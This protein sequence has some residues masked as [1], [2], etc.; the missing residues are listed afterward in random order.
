MLGSATLGVTMAWLPM[1]YLIGHAVPDDAFY[2]F[3]TAR[4]IVH[5]HGVSV[6]GEVW[7][8]GFHPLWM[9]MLIPIFAVFRGDSETPIHVAL[10]LSALLTSASG[11]L[12]Y[13]TARRLGLGGLAAL[14]ATA[15]YLFHPIVVFMSINGLETGLNLSIFVAVLYC[16]VRAHQK[17]ST[18]AYIL[19][20]SAAGLL[21]LSRTDYSIAAAAMLLS[22]TWRSRRPESIGTLVLPAVL[23]TA[24]WFLWNQIVFGSPLQG[25]ADAVPYVGHKLFR[26]SD[27]STLGM[28]HHAAEQMR[29]GA[30]STLP[31]FYFTPTRATAGIAVAFV[32]LIV[33]TAAIITSPAARPAVRDFR[34]LAVPAAGLGAQFVV[35]AGIRWYLREW[36]LVAVFPL[37]ALTIALVAQAALESRLRLAGAALLGAIVLTATVPTATRTYGHGWYPVQLD[38]LAAAR[39]IDASTP[40]DTRVG[41]FNSGLVGYYSHRQTINLDGVMNPDASDA[42]R[43]RELGAYLDRRGID[44]LADF[45]LY[46]LYVY[47]G[48]IGRPLSERVVASFDAHPTFQGP[49][50]VYALGPAP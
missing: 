1:H 19:A 34:R 5:G 15:L 42:I 47:R 46:P 45:P 2:Y 48:F 18:A 4:N 29:E 7:A 33:L 10:T 26:Q 3:Q 40:R 20:S 12:L 30:L 49:F 8:N 41:T 25:S 9:L 44:L 21:I 13:L 31:Y 37:I 39:W 35:H 43:R 27:S 17:P 11:V 6:D 14:I 38:M 24:P 22:L 36:Y 23:I 32:V 28:L 50:S 16:F